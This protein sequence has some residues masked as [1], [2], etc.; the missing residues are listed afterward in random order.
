MRNG[1][2]DK[3]NYRIPDWLDQPK[4]K[5]D[6]PSQT[7]DPVDQ[8]PQEPPLLSNVLPNLQKNHQSPPPDQTISEKNTDI[9]AP[10]SIENRQYTPTYQVK[11][12]TVLF[13]ILIFAL[14]VA[15]SFYAGLYFEQSRTATDLNEYDK[16]VQSLH[17]QKQTPANY[18]LIPPSVAGVNDRKDIPGGADP[19]NLPTGDYKYN[20]AD[21]PRE[22]GLNYFRLVQIPADSEADGQKIIK[23]LS[24]NGVDAALIPIKNGTYYKLLALKGFSKPIS[25]PKAQQYRKLLLKLGRKWKSELKGSTNWSDM[26]PEKY[27]PGRN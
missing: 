26:I 23:Y 20:P 5:K 2:G 21:D 6:Q 12:H 13:S 15:G 18:G 11:Q 25:D 9:P 7:S 22:P 8:T 4:P 1:K 14:M 17:P 10:E 19:N 24:A 27:R 16:L 3:P